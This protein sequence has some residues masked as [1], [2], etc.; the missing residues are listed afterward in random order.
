MVTINPIPRALVP[1]DSAAAQRLCSPNYDEFQNDREITELLERQPD[2]VLS[3][4]MPHA[5]PD[6]EGKMLPEGSAEALR[7]A[8]ERMSALQTGTLTR[9][10]N[11]A[12]FLY[13]ITDPRRPG[14]RQ[15]GLGGMVSASDIQTD[16]N[17]R[18][19]IVRNEGVRPPK[20]RGRADL[21]EATR[22]IIGVVNNAVEDR[23]D[24]FVTALEAEAGRCAPD[25]GARAADGCTHSVWLVTE[26]AA[27]DGLIAAAAAEPFAY[28]ADGNHRSAAASMLGLEGFLAVAF[29][30]SRMGLAPYNRL[31]SAGGRP[32]SQWRE[33]LSE[34]FTVRDAPGSGDFQPTATHSVGLY[35]D[36][37]W[38]A[39]TP[40]SGTF[41]EGNAAQSIDAA[42]V[43]RLVF[44]RLCGIPDPSDE[45]LTFVGGDRD[46]SY[47]RGRV[48]S[49]EYAFAVTVPPVTMSQF[50]EVCRQRRMMPP[51]STWFSPKI[52]SGMV[53]A[54]LD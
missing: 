45:R 37:T 23:E 21:I 7:V 10:V 22:A 50:I 3:I 47:L 36:G 41:E 49:G 30:A 9:E 34:Y 31:V 32:V 28:V 44:E 14:T 2:S 5:W 17:P 1:A 52:R 35:A 42:I 25:Y 4:T 24:Q 48:D 43:Q 29:P 53:M 40:R 26:P 38:L 13:E 15:I 8:A 27:R 18:G 39:L 54:L 51:K 12:V 46:A 6:A 20:A 16:R 33:D 19:T 11:E